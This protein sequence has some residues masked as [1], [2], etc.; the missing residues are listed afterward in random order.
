MRWMICGAASV[1]A[2]EPESPAEAVR[3]VDLALA[4]RYE[5]RDFGMG[6][7]RFGQRALQIAIIGLPVTG[8]EGDGNGQQDRSHGSPF[9]RFGCTSRPVRGGEQSRCAG[10]R[11]TLAALW[12]SS[13]CERRGRGAG[14]R[15]RESVW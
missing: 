15:P 8:N 1:R 14:N 4:N 5:P 13:A 11:R 6:A 10:L 9:H 7:G 3:F 12:D 2:D